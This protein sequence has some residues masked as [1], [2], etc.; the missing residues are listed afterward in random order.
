VVAYEPLGRKGPDLSINGSLYVEVTRIH[1]KQD[2]REKLATGKLILIP[3]LSQTIYS[4]LQY[5][6]SQLVETNA[7]LLLVRSSRG[8]AD[9]GHVRSAFHQLLEDSSKSGLVSGMVFTDGWR[10]W[11]GIDPD[12]TRHLSSRI[13]VDVNLEAT[14]PVSASLTDRLQAEVFP[15]CDPLVQEYCFGA[16]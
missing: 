2:E 13:H 10:S 8:F 16:T 5:K 14:V 3:D 1:E 7:N 12:G 11:T 4:K 15:P 9:Y 6:L